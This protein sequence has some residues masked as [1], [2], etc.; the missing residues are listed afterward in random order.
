[1]NRAGRIEAALRAAPLDEVLEMDDPA[2]VASAMIPL[3]TA[4]PQR[5]D[6]ALA[7]QRMAELRMQLYQAETYAR[8]QELQATPEDNRSGVAIC[9]IVE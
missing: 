2:M 9:R 7:Q 6:D 4:L 8:L 3:Q 5:W 1:M